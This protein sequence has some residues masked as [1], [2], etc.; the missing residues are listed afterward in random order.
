MKYNDS[1]GWEDLKYYYKNINGRPIEYVKIDRELEKLG[2]KG[3]GKAYPVESIKIE[4]WRVHAEN[5]LNQR[6][7]T[8]EQALSYMDN[9]V[10]MM[11]KYPEPQTQYNYYSEEGLIGVLK[12]SCLVATVF[13]KKQFKDD[14]VAILEVAKKRLKS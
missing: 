11:K 5:R 12:D 13:S 7:I 6:G 1:E 10:V 3:K 14:S 2:I 4:G 8:K 9:A